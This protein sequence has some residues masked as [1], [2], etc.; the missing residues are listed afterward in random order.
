M[1]AT[2]EMTVQMLLCAVQAL[3]TLMDQNIS[4]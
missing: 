1:P 3:T 4:E 2:Y